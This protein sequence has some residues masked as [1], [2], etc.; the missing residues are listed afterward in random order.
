MP[1]NRIYSD[2]NQKDDFTTANLVLDIASVYQSVTNILATPI[3]TRLFN[4]E[5]GSELE[6]LLFQPMD[7]I[8]AFEIETF[9]TSAVDRWE[10]RIIIDTG[11][12]SVIPNYDNHRYDVIL[13]M[14]V[15]G[16]EDKIFEYQAF[17]ERAN[18]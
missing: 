9:L 1:D 18:P 5:F 6:D 16:L 4:P 14:R 10:N 17:L 12:S 3:L 13:V 7:D 2:I 15:V 11:Q 8:T